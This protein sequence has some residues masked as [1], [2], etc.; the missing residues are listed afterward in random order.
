MSAWTTNRES[1]QCTVIS[2][3]TFLNLRRVKETFEIEITDRASAHCHWLPKAE[4][5][6]FEVR[7]PCSILFPYYEF[8]VRNLFSTVALIFVYNLY[9]SPTVASMQISQSTNEIQFGYSISLALNPPVSN[10]WRIVCVNL[11]FKIPLQIA[12]RNCRPISCFYIAVIAIL[13][14]R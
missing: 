4:E 10:A 6:R 14:P 7:Q 3:A 12:T 11:Y 9:I 1:A 5:K 13:H 2:H 8:I